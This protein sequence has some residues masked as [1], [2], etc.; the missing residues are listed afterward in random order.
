MS[1]NFREFRKR[2]KRVAITS[3]ALTAMLAT[4]VISAQEVATTN[5]AVNFRDAAGMDSN[6]METLPKGTKVNVLDDS[7]NWV[8]VEYNG[9][10]GYV[11][12]T[13]LETKTVKVGTVKVGDSR[14]NVRQKPSMSSKIIGKLYNGNKVEIKGESGNW[15]EIEYKGKTAYVSK[16]Y[17]KTSS[18]TI[19]EIEECSD[20]FKAETGFN[21]RTG[22]STSKAKMGRII[23]G[24]VFQV[25]G[26]CQNGWYLIQYGSKEGYISPMYLEEM[27]DGATDPQVIGTAKVD[28]RSNTKKNLYIRAGQSADTTAL[29]KAPTGTILEVLEDEHPVD[30][31]T[32]VRYKNLTGYCAT[33]YLIIDKETPEEPDENNAPVIEC[34]DEIHY[35]VGQ[36]FAITDLQ[37]IVNDV[38]DGNIADKAVVDTSKVDTSKAGEYTIIITVEDS[39]GA[40]AS[41]EV[42]VIVEDKEVKNEAPVISC[43]DELV[44]TVGD[45]FTSVDINLAVTDKED[46]DL[47]DKAVVDTSNVDLSKAG[48]YKIMITVKDSKGAEATKEV[49]VIVKDKEVPNE[50]PVISCVDTLE[51]T[52]GDAFTSADINLK[53]TDKEDGDLTDKAVIDSSNVDLSKAGEYT[54]TITVKDSKGAEATKTIKVTVKDKENPEVKNEA[55][56]IKSVDELVYTVGDNFVITDLQLEVTDAEDGNLADKAVIDD[57]QVDFTKAG[58]YKITISVEDS[59]GEKASKDVKV[60]IKEKE[61]KNEAPVISSEDELT[62][63]VGDEFVM[64]DL[65]LKVTDAEDGDITDKAI[66]DVTNVDTTKAGQYTI[67]ISVEDSKGEKVSKDVK[68]VVKDKETPETPEVNEK[69]EITASDVTITVGDSFSKD[70]LNIKATDAEDGDLTDKVEISGDVNATKAGEYTLTL[71]VK[72]SKGEEAKTTVKVTVKEK[73]KENTAPVLTVSDLTTDCGDNFKY[74]MLN[75]KA[76]D[77]EDGTIT[78]FDY[79][80]DVDSTKV[81]EYKVKV[82]VKDSQ[83]LT[84]SKTVKVTVKSTKPVITAEDA[85]ITVGDDFSSGTINAS[86]KDCEGN[87]IDVD[88]PATAVNTTK[89]GTYSVKVSAT[90]K[91][92]NTAT[93]TVKVT[94]KEKE[95][96]GY[97][98]NSP[99]CRRIIQDE[100]YKLVNEHRANNGKS[101]L[102]VSS[103][104]ENT[105]YLKSEDMGINNYFDHQVDGK[106]IWEYKDCADA[107]AENIAKCGWNGTN[108]KLTEQDC[109]DLANSIFNMWKES[110]GHNANMLSKKNQVIGFDLYLVDRGNDA[111]TVYATQEFRTK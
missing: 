22:P 78:D 70:L 40:K 81:G 2:M 68:V 52:V 84:D 79:S 16:K 101:A 10:T 66:V 37:L 9:K 98:V 91:W 106:F 25:K 26:K 73:E 39:Q 111:Y 36:E 45:A 75:A 64:T 46:G 56:V 6:I 12:K 95:V 19:S 17:V 76:E 77:A 102:T 3:T 85:T 72:D 5:H 96:Q 30:G 63:T 92:G 71:T 90:D 32:R 51:F 42:K 20:T 38:E 13:Y 48:E 83:G 49:K 54:I 65:N 1:K 88:V 24:Q 94:V 41:K 99:E 108:G 7:T 53:V 57:S 80:G 60:T 47:T 89:A 28:T 87:K 59:K 86:A 21:V 8:Q 69:P 23:K 35:T 93:K 58:E 110:T 103:A 55:P 18:T 107:D 31:W 11:Y 62:Y 67:T 43:E 44:Y 34:A 82:T 50:A 29:D 14:L 61:V 4:M 109:K 105:A 97:K 104:L 15:Y 100:M 33:K 27:E 74:S